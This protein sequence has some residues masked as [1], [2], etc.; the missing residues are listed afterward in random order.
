MKRSALYF[1]LIA[2]WLFA[3]NVS[4]FFPAKQESEDAYA[5]AALVEQVEARPWYSLTDPNHM[6]YLPMM[7]GLWNGVLGVRHWVVEEEKEHRLSNMSTSLLSQAPA[8]LP[9]SVE[10]QVPETR[11]EPSEGDG[12]CSLDPERVALSSRKHCYN[13]SRAHYLELSAPNNLMPRASCLV[14]SS[15]RAAEVMR[16]AS[17]LFGA[18]GVFL[19]M[20]LFHHFLKLSCPQSIFSGLL[21]GFSYAYWRYSCEVEIYSLAA[22]LGV[23]SLCSVFAFC[24]SAGRN[25]ERR[26]GWLFVGSGLLAGFSLTVHLGLIPV[27]VASFYYMV[28]RFRFKTWLL[29]FATAAVWV[30]GIYGAD[31]WLGS[32]YVSEYATVRTKMLDG[33]DAFS[34][35]SGRGAVGQRDCV[36]G[37]GQELSD[38]R[39]AATNEQPET[40]NVVAV[41]CGDVLVPFFKYTELDVHSVDAFESGVLGNRFR[42]KLL[43][44]VAARGF[45]GAAQ[46]LVCGNFLFSYEWVREQLVAHFPYRDLSDDLHFGT[47][48]D[49]HPMVYVATAT[50]ALW[51]L[52][53]LFALR[54]VWMHWRWI[55][56]CVRTRKGQ[57]VLVW[58]GIALAMVL[59]REPDNPELWSFPILP[60]LILLAVILCRTIRYRAVYFLILML[61]V[62]HN[63]CG[64]IGLLQDVGCDLYQVKTL[65]LK[66]ELEPRDILVTNADPI[67]VRYYRY[68]LDNPIISMQQI[69]GRGEGTLLCDGVPDGFR[70]V[71]AADVVDL[72]RY[73]KYRRPQL[74]ERM[75]QFK[76]EIEALDNAK[77]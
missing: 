25:P 35:S 21:I 45:L 73:L 7:R 9:G 8:W 54:Y 53:V 51:G 44:E 49:G 55:W 74:Y 75:V 32:K 72:P 29:Y 76:S 10:D 14:L 63:W 48:Y 6:L 39:L 16:Y 17:A 43:G 42:L 31:A 67:S 46:S 77:K 18:A 13:Q 22:F 15:L 57:A 34:S 62:A 30:G 5:Y 4:V 58:F 23:A 36:Q 28:R 65:R 37:M 64:G 33:D 69:L 1:S 3:L 61:L 52:V 59:A 50:L 60:F 66:Q 12:E 26:L 47:F 11:Y 19:L 68:L 38:S 27:I 71:F 70:F 2:I 20:C 56:E 40:N 24:R 41:V